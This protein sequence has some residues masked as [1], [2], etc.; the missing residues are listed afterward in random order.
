MPDL[1]PLVVLAP[2]DEVG[3]GEVARDPLVEAVDLGLADLDLGDDQA[4][5]SRAARCIGS[6]RRASG[7]LAGPADQPPSS[8]EGPCM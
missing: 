1:A 6:R 2:V 7:G 4:L 5:A 8:Q 3:L